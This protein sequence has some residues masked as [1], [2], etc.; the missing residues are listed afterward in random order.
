MEAQVEK[1]DG[2][3]VVRDIATE[4]KNMLDFKMNAVMVRMIVS[5]KTKRP[6]YIV[7]EHLQR[8]VESA[9]QAAVSA[10]RD[11]NVVPKYYP[12]QRFD[13][14][15]DGKMSGTGQEPL[16]STN[17]HFD[18]LAVNITFSAVLLP[19]GVKEIGKYI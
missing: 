3:V 8:L 17:R 13:V 1:K 15:S 10:P 11:G 4:V 5:Q 16:L 14:A 12:S 2:L 6:L 9:E 7:N 18:H 19:A